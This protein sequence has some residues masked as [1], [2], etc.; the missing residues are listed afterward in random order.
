MIRISSVVSS[1]DDQTYALIGAAMTVHRELGHGFLEPVY[2]EALAREFAENGIPF[3][4]EHPLQILYRGHPLSSVY[5]VDFLCFNE[6]IVELKALRRLSAVEESQVV[7][8]LKASGLQRGLVLNFGT[9][10]LEYK[11]LIWSPE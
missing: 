8:Y 6:I 4:R 1:G 10:R 5:R 11:R 2:Q 7:H 3:A 9:N